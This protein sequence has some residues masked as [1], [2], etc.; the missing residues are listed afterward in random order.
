MS[1]NSTIKLFSSEIQWFYPFILKFALT[2]LYFSLLSQVACGI[3]SNSLAPIYHLFMHL[4]LS[5]VQYNTMVKLLK[6]DILYIKK[7]KE[8]LI[9]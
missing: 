7:L 9:W 8:I 6:L 5:F 2:F 3:I 4:Y 1:K